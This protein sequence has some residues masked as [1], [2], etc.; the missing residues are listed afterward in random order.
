MNKQQP[1]VPVTPPPSALPFAER[2]DITPL[3]NAGMGIVIV[4]DNADFPTDSLLIVK[5]SAA[6]IILRL[7]QD[8]VQYVGVPSVL[9][10]LL[11][12]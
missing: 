3:L 9:T 5:Q 1:A 6:P 10:V 4:D 8:M 2:A 12:F 11:C 7:A